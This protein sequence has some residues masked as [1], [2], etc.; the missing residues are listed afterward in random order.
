VRRSA[1]AYLSDILAACD[2]IEEVRSG[3]DLL[4][5]WSGRS[6]TVGA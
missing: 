3:V 6:G 2:A 1:A 5:Y 4:T